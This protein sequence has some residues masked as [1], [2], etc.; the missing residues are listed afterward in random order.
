[1]VAAL[2]L[3]ACRFAFAQTPAPAAPAAA[4]QEV[5]QL[6]KFEVTEKGVNP[7]QSS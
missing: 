3:G 2:S 7:Y 6:P 1:M 5:I 4:D